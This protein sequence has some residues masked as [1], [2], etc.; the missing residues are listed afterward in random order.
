MSW[1]HCCQ[2][3]VMEP[4]GRHW[5]PR[6]PR[7]SR[8]VT[9]LAR[10]WLEPSTSGLLSSMASTL[11]QNVHAQLAVRLRKHRRR[12]RSGRYRRKT[13]TYVWKNRRVIV[14]FVN[15]LFFPQRPALRLDG[16][17]Y[18]PRVLEKLLIT[19]SHIPSF[20]LAADVCKQL[21]GIRVSGRHLQNLTSKIGQELAERRDTETAEYF[22]QPLPR[23][24]TCPS[25]PIALAC[26]SID[27]G[28]MQT[29]EQGCGVGVHSPHWRESK[30]ALFSRMSG[31]S[32][33]TD[34][35]PEL[36]GCYAD[37][38]RMQSLLT[39]VEREHSREEG[40][41]IRAA[42]W[43]AEKLF[44]TCLSSLADSEMF[45]RMMAAEADLRGF[46]NAG[47]RAFVCDGLPYNW[48]I[49]QQHFPDF[50]PILDFVHAIEHSHA[51]A[52][53]STGD[54]EQAWKLHL[55]WA[56]ALWKG[57]VDQVISQLQQ[58]QEEIG[59]PPKD[60]EDN[61]PRKIVADTIR[62]FQNNAARMD[63]PSYRTHGLPTTSAQMES[64]VKEVNYRVKGS[65]K[66]WND[67]TN[68]EAILQVR[69]AALGDDQRLARHLR[70]R[71]GSPFRPNVDAKAVLAL[72][73]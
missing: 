34:P 56:A 33:P 26:V 23:Q 1:W 3:I 30:N 54:S 65:E 31:V 17:S 70:N 5:T 13:G 48:T 69:A 66:F 45:G 40:P 28:R 36:P 59:L 46:Y 47:K 7:L 11:K 10:W 38:T 50:T 64:F 53:A 52:R 16:R 9:R 72:A 2:H 25:T 29:R 6:L 22:N 62:Y 4:R 20:E 71:P 44:R 49:Q 41:R 32:F 21:T 67:G 58:R 55:G 8:T 51:A 73:G 57:Q 12:K 15:G 14:P 27:G 35:H 39:G 42:K 37:R 24:A 61:D 68:G 63:Y 18:S 60:A 43:R 19:S